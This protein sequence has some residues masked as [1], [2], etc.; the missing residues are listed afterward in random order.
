M[1]ELKVTC[2]YC[3]REISIDDKNILRHFARI[4]GIARGIKIDK[5][6]RVEIAKLGANARWSRIRQKEPTSNI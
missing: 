5:A 6:R 3:G 2:P 4:G 1:N